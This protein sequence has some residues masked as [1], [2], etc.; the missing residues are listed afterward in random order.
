MDHR[1]S[2][3]DGDGSRI[4]QF[5]FVF[6]LRAWATTLEV[7]LHRA[8]TGR[9][10]PGMFAAGGA[11]LILFFGAFFPGRDARPLLVYLV[12]FLIACGRTRAA[13]AWRSW[14]R[15]AHEYGWYTGRPWLLVLCPRLGE[16]RIKRFV[17]PLAVFVGSYFVIGWNEPL[18]AYLIG[19][20]ISLFATVNAAE[21]REQTRALDM[22]DNTVLQRQLAERFRR[23]EGSRF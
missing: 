9:R 8:P 18:G 16:L 21:A 3:P 22:Y 13:T 11:L 2:N 19:A 12:L 1:S 14:R 17:E 7:F 6:T 4:L 23:L 15:G 5:W 20:S 10:W